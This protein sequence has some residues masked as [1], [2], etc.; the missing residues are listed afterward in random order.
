MQTRDGAIVATSVIVDVRTLKTN[1]PQRDETLR[2]SRGPIW[3]KHPYGTSTPGS[4]PAR[5]D[6]RNGGSV[7]DVVARGMLRIHDVDRRVEFPLQLESSTF[8]RS[9]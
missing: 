7:A 9:G 6:R 1:D 2:S 4:Q 5:L 3:D 8:V